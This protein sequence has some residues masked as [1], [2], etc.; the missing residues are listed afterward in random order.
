MNFVSHRSTVLATCAA[1]IASVAAPVSAQT[2]LFDFNSAPLYS[3]LP[4]NLT[5]GGITAHFTSTGQ[6]FSI[7]GPGAPVVPL[8][9]TGRFIYPSS[10][11]PADL[12]ISFDQTLTSFSILYSPEE[13]GCDDSATM[14]VTAKM[15]GVFVGSSTKTASNPGTWPVD[16]LACSFAQG[17]NSVVVHYDSQPPTCSDWGGIFLADDMRVTPLASAATTLCFGDGSSGPCPCGNSGQPGAGCANSTGLGAFMSATGTG[18]VS[19]DDLVL[20]T[21]GMPPSKSAVGFWSATILAPAPFHDGRRCVFA[22]I[23]RLPLLT[24]DANGTVVYGPGLATSQGF[25]AGTTIGFQVW[26]RDP[27]GPCGTT[28]NISSAVQVQFAP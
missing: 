17:F 18:S 8:G 4:I 21:G 28:S 27:T 11:N 26:Y 14:R 9:F 23:R 16:T 25:V 13:Y 15:N 1:A 24:S 3:P 20:S 10:I 22:P 7:Q 12:L 2:V 5:E 6:G 19:S